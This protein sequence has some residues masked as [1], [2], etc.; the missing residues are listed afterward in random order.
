MLLTPQDDR[1]VL[2]WG[3]GITDCVKRASRMAS[4][5]RLH[6]FRSGLP[7]LPSRIGACTP[8]LICFNGLMGYRQ[9]FDSTAQLGL[10]PD[11]LAGAKVFVVPSTSAANAGF[12]REERVEWFRRLHD[13]RNRLPNP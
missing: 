7:D 13:L 4:E 3:I 8:R 1:R 12:T 5:V 6:E 10:Q 11:E 2:D 9:A